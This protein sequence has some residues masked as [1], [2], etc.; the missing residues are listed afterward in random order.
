MKSMVRVELHATDMYWYLTM[1]QKTV[2]LKQNEKRPT[3]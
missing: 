3:S 2:K 1:Y